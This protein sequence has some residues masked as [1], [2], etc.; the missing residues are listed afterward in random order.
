MISAMDM[1]LQPNARVK[2]PTD[3]SI[4]PLQGT[5][6]QL[7]QRYGLAVHHCIDTKAGVIDPDYKGKIIV[8]LHNYRTTTYDIKVGDHIA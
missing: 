1:A 3:I 5:Y 7:M 6:G 4:V 8:S 2:I